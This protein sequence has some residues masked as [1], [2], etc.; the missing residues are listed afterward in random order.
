MSKEGYITINQNPFSE[1]APTKLVPV[2]N[3]N[4][5]SPTDLYVE[6]A[7]EGNPE[8]D[9]VSYLNNK[10]TAYPTNK[11]FQDLMFTAK[12]RGQGYDDFR[13]AISPFNVRVVDSVLYDAGGNF[14]NLPGLEIC[15][16]KNPYLQVTGEPTKNNLYVD[17]HPYS[18][19]VDMGM[20]FGFAA[21]N[22][23]DTVGREIVSYDQ[24]SIQM[25]WN[26]AT[27]SGSLKTWLVRGCPYI[28]FQ[29]SALPFVMTGLNMLTISTDGG[30]TSYSLPD[31]H[32][33][34][35][36]S[37]FTGTKF[38]LVIGGI[39]RQATNLQNYYDSN[40]NLTCPP[41][42][43]VYMLYFENPV[44]LSF[45]PTDSKHNYQK[46][47]A[48]GNDGQ[49]VPYTGVV[50]VAYVSSQTGT[51]GEDEVPAAMKVNFYDAQEGLTA[52]ANTYPIGASLELQKSGDGAK[53]LQIINWQVQN[54]TLV[55]GFINKLLMSDFLNLNRNTFVSSDEEAINTLR[56]PMGIVVGN[57]WQI[58]IDLPYHL[59]DANLWEY[60]TI[61]SQYLDEIEQQLKLDTALPD[62]NAPNFNDSYS[63]GKIIAKAS[64]LVLIA[65]QIGD[66]ETRDNILKLMKEKLELWFIME[67]PNGDPNGL[68]QGFFKY[69]SKFGGICTARALANSDDGGGYQM[70][71]C[72]GQYTDHHFHYGYF[73][74]A[75]AIIARFDNEWLNQW[76]EYVNL[77]ARDIANPALNDPYFP[78]Y[79]HFDWFEGHGFANGYTPS[80]SGRNQESTSEAVNT[81]YAL[82]LWGNVSGNP[83][84]QGLGQIMCVLE[85]KAAK[86]FTQ[87]ENS[88]LMIAP[89]TLFNPFNTS[90]SVQDTL[91][92]GVNWSLKTD[93]TTFFGNKL[94]FLVGIQIMPYTPIT[95]ALIDASFIINKA[96]QFQA[97]YGNLVNIVKL[98]A[99]VDVIVQKFG[100]EL[101]QTDKSADDW[102]RMF[103]AML[104][105]WTFIWFMILAP[106]MAGNDQEG[107]WKA[108]TQSM[109]NLMNA[110]TQAF[111]DSNRVS[112]VDGQ[113]YIKDD[114]GINRTISLPFANMQLDA[115]Q[116]MTNIMWWTSTI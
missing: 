15:A 49:S 113:A 3:D 81:W 55:D 97:L 25:V 17:F 102:W 54:C 14:N 99:Q 50:R 77:L 100:Q 34:D 4:G 46:L 16:P 51:V 116:S 42:Y 45:T 96:L 106:T 28:T 47:T 78:Q 72:N 89:N 24:F 93:H 59:Q 76:K 57:S 73:L 86:A 41:L 38:K 11:W 95:N 63:F 58:E 114:Q 90:I 31:S 30:K 10:P 66:T 110:V 53:A 37:T 40:G 7:T 1:A 8:R 70:D 87:I 26:N 21:G 68:T 98:Y 112:I 29:Y 13:V 107:T 62:L 52:Y 79:R 60:Q 94:A 104:N 83:D 43:S 6:Y 36:P 92:S 101:A 5:I 12:Q 19:L 56:G 35:N 75:S 80:A 69:D 108:I 61:D 33:P 74:Y 85:I 2:G 27:N 23:T 109:P 44:T 103:Q 9:P 18:I 22:E 105:D 64:R 71:Y 82:A 65:D 20:D 84:M 111:K 67:A 115:G 48:I 32:A 39:D 91:M 88:N